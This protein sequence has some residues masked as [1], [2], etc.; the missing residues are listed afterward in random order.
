MRTILAARK[1]SR[2]T[3]EALQLDGRSRAT[4]SISFHTVQ[5]MAVMT[6][7]LISWLVAVFGWLPT[8]CN[9]QVG[10]LRH[11][12]PLRLFRCQ[13]TPDRCR[14]RPQ[15]QSWRV[16][17][18]KRRCPVTR[19][20][21]KSPRCNTCSRFTGI[22]IDRLP[23]ST[24]FQISLRR[25]QVACAALR[26]NDACAKVFRLSLAGKCARARGAK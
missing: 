22:A 10:V 14:L 26:R 6:T 25:T 3:S 12:L 7:T 20:P 15:R 19:R 17:P 18:L 24:S 5:V 8:Y 11:G 21:P 1:I 13:R 2:G 9:T 16:G 23:S 4:R